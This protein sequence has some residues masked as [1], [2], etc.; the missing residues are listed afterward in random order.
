MKPDPLRNYTPH[1]SLHTTYPVYTTIM[2]KLL[3]CIAILL[4][5]TWVTGFFS[6]NTGNLMAMGAVILSKFTD[7]NSLRTSV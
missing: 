4:L 3:Y 2:N 5:V 7:S 6:T 1:A